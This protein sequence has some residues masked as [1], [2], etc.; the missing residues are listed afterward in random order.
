[1]HKGH[2]HSLYFLLVCLS[3][4]VWLMYRII[5]PFINA[6]ILA[7]VFAFLLQPIYRIFL[8]KFRD[9]AT[10]AAGATTI[11]ALVILIIPFSFLAVQ[12]FHE[13]S[14]L[15]QTITTGGDSAGFTVAIQN[16][17]TS[18]RN[19]IPLPFDLDINFL[20]YGKQALESVVQNLGNIV[21][22]VAHVFMSAFICLA[23]F[24]FLLKD[25]GK[26]KDY[27]VKVSPLDDVDDESIVERLQSA[28]SATVK[29]S[30]TIAFI[31]G[32]VAGIGFL[33]FG[34][35]NAALWGTVTAIS[36]LIPGIGTSLVLVP[37]IIYLFFTG[38]SFGGIG[39]L[40][41]AVIAV[42]L[43]DNALG[44]RL[45]SAGMKLHPFAVFLSVIGG[46]SFFGPLGILLGPLTLS[47]CLALVDIYFSLR[48]RHEPGEDLNL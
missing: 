20:Q 18:L 28:I 41:W 32:F 48:A 12:I 35:P 30:L 38:N 36:A 29:G 33:L 15:Y 3:L 40:I 7:S 16:V 9:H 8:K 22:S 46:L 11:L 1:M 14:Q 34:V 6:L 45:V 21:S 19:A 43:I 24:F 37:A 17:V 42:G 25:G 31:Q 27:L 47:M 5:S 23:A 39:L 2:Q 13:A 26:L 10:L 44:P 4:A